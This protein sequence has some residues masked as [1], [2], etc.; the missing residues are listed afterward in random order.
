[1]N[2]LKLQVVDGAIGL[3][4]AIAGFSVGDNL[5]LPYQ[6]GSAYGESACYLGYRCEP[7]VPPIGCPSAGSCIVPPG[8]FSPRG[9]EP[10]GLICTYRC[11]CPGTDPFTGQSCCTAHA[12][13]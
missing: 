3:V 8:V 10:S 5:P 6:P 11:K 12:C 1:M 13:P 4:V 9:C 2:R 7:P